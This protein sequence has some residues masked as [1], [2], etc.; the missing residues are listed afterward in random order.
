M[1]KETPRQKGS[2]FEAL[3]ITSIKEGLEWLLTFTSPTQRWTAGSKEL[4]DGATTSPERKNPK[5]QRH[6]AA[7]SIL[8]S[9]DSAFPCQTYFS[10]LRISG[11]IGRRRRANAALLFL[12]PL[13][14]YSNWGHEIDVRVAQAPAN[15]LIP[16]GS[17]VAVYCA[18]CK[19]LF[20]QVAYIQ[21]QN[22]LGH[23]EGC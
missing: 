19:S 16:D 1:C 4:T 22:A 15:L 20:M 13:M 18:R 11:V 21:Q 23:R 6:E 5:K 3:I 12:A 7:Q 14:T 8:E 10:P 2:V 17:Q 9:R